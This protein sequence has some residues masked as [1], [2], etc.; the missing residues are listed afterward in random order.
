MRASY[1]VQ[2]PSL[3][4]VFGDFGQLRSSQKCKHL[5]WFPPHIYRFSLEF[6]Y[7]H[8]VCFSDLT[9]VA[10]NDYCPDND[11]NSFVSRL[12]SGDFCTIFSSM[13]DFLSQNSP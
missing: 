3:S 12:C 8:C 9:L 11:L 2:K 1:D 7:L 6:A 5:L 4:S 10:A 13:C